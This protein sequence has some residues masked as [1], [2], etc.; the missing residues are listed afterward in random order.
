MIRCEKLEE[1]SP[2]VLELFDDD[3]IGED[4]M[5]RA[6]IHVFFLL[7]LIVEGDIKFKGVGAGQ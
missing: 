7:T 4:Y 6:V 1:T 3:F 5:G 2:M